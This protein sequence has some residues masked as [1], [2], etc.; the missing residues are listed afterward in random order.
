[1]S[2]EEHPN[3][4]VVAPDDPPASALAKLEEQRPKNLFIHVVRG[5]VLYPGMMFPL[6]ISEGPFQKILEQVEQQRGFLGLLFGTDEDASKAPRLPEGVSKVG[7]LAQFV[8]PLEAPDGTRAA[9]FQLLARL[10]VDKWVSTDPFL[11]ARVEYPS[12][13]HTHPQEIEGLWRACQR[14]VA[15]ILEQNAAF[16][17]QLNVVAANIDGPAL[18]ADFAALNFK[19]RLEE[20][21]EVLESFDL[22]HRLEC[23]LRALHRELDLW[24]LGEKIQHEI[25]EKV[26]KTQKEFFLREQLKAIRHELG[27]EVDERSLEVELY[28]KKL[29][30]L[31]MSPEAERAARE[32]LKRFAVLPVEAAES[33]VVRAYLDWLTGLPWGIFTED[34]DDIDRAQAMLD[35][36]HFGLDE[37]KER[38]VEQL[39]VRK[40]KADL[41]GA[42]LCLCG[43]PGVGKTSLGRSVAEALGR[44]FYRFSLGGM[45]DEAEIKGH[46]RTYVGALPG[47]LV[48]ALKEAGSSNPV[49]MLDEIDKLGTDFRGDPASAL[50]EALDPEQNHAFV[51]HYLDVPYDLSRVI[52]I[53][54][55]NVKSSIPAP[56]L[57]RMEVIELPGYIPRE[58]V[59]IAVRHL[60]P[61]QLEHNGLKPKQLQLGRS[62]IR[63]IVLGHTREAGVRNLEREI[64]KICRKVAARVAR[65]KRRPVLVEADNLT[66]Y[67]GPPRFESDFGTRCQ[68]PG[69][70]VGLA[71]TPFGGEVLL[72]EVARMKGT[73]GL[74]VTGQL[75]DVM[76]ESTQIALS[77]VRSK[78]EQLDIPA[79][80]F[81]QSELH[82][83]FPAGAVP[84]DGPSAG[85]TIT[86][87]L[88]SLLTRG[89]KG[90][91]IRANV[92]MTGEMTLRGDVLPIGGLREKLVAAKQAGVK[93]VILP[94]RNQKDLGEIP[95]YLR[96]GLRIALVDTFDEVLET[97]F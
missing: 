52:F 80:L 35:R 62:A 82:I 75:G 33:G 54:T 43:P 81:E 71:W 36:D 83:H 92:A 24:K 57:D 28:Q 16:P 85:I 37:V 31:T 87:A 90:R 97:A 64:G 29:D 63:A 67:L 60:L 26:E 56:L 61:K 32:Q 72:I 95:E 49:L 47:K 7:V 86:T 68:R 69:V 39:A 77:Y 12:D 88:V 94:R 27:E 76:K 40:L 34:H 20:R 66:A 53:A 65:G 6:P 96:K 84:K 18:F 10:R 51:D 78:A 19:L 91:S 17:R 30:A 1:M 70:A 58:K 4:E 9:L 42:I 48:R 22:R 79:T 2:E 13:V 93:T 74:R 73:G 41:K 45:R 59:E 14:V 25:R 89:G 46:R 15:E 3:V 5:V 21:I 11:V 38:I 23:V 55:A 8:R 50:L 44:K